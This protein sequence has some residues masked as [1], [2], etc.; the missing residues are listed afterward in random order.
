MWGALLHGGRVVVVS[1]EVSRDPWR[2]LRLLADEHVTVLSQ[3]PAAFH[4]M[5]LACAAE[6]ELAERLALRYVVFGGE[7]LSQGQIA[8][9][10]RR[11]PERGPRLINMYGITETTWHLTFRYVSPALA[12]P[13]VVCGSAR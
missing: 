7:A 10:Q 11:N 2:M 3:T 9:W 4:A 6:P 8:D 12:R 1:G 13:V 5:D